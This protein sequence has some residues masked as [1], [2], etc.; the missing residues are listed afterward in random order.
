M[1]LYVG[2][3]YGFGWCVVLVGKHETW[4]FYERQGFKRYQRL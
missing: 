3:D 4:G 2:S 1:R